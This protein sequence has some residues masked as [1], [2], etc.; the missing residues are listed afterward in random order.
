MRGAYLIVIAVGALGAAACDDGPSLR[1]RGIRE[2][3][4]QGEHGEKRPPAPALLVVEPPTHRTAIEGATSPELVFERAQ[5][6]IEN[7]DAL[8]LLFSIRPE[9]RR[10]WLADLVVAVAVASSD[11]GTEPDPMLRRDRAHVREMLRAYGAFGAVEN[12]AD[13][14]ADGVSRALLEKVKYPDGLYAALLDFAADHH[15]DYDPV[16]A[17]EPS[18]RDRGPDPTAASLLRLVRRVR[19]PNQI[20]PVDPADGQALTLAPDAGPADTAFLPVRFATKA[21]TV[22]LDE[23]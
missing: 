12:P 15:A 14:S 22:W 1:E 17:L 3:H 13:L 11:D 9:T 5:R 6:A 16:R 8:E 18:K 10:R 2:V 7:R 20:G 4:D 23:S 19:A 21:G